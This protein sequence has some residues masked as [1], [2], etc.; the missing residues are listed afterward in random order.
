MKPH[1]SHHHHDPRIGF[2]DNHAPRWEADAEANTRTLERLTA[3]QPRLGLRPGMDVLEV[4]CGTGLV[5]SW[6]V[7]CVQP[8]RVLA[9][10]FSPVMLAQAQAKSLM[11]EFRCLDICHET[12]EATAFDVAFCFHVFPH[13]RDQL[14]AL[15]HLAAA[16]R[17]AGR[18]LVLHL[19]GSAQINE[20]HQGLNGPVSQDRLPPA[21][22]WPALLQ[23]AGLQLLVGDDQPGLFLLVA[24]RA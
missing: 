16:L 12:P 14:A 6:L 4:G 18:L 10:D 24:K 3:L 23:A 7:N 17:P 22:E 15:R 13:F 2:F 19:A 11:A 5:T 9:V 8:G 21:T 1:H 20:F